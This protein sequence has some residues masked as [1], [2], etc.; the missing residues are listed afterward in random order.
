[1]IAPCTAPILLVSILRKHRYRLAYLYLLAPILLELCMSF[2]ISVDALLL[3]LIVVYNQSLSADLPINGKSLGLRKI[4]ITMTESTL[5]SLLQHFN[6]IQSSCTAH[7]G[8]GRLSR[9]CDIE[10]VVQ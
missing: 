1:M 5:D 3:G 6:N 10:Q 7:H 2:K 8:D 9:L 4:H